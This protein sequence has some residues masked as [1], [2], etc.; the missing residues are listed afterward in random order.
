MYSGT[1]LTAM[2]GRILGAHQK[3]DRVA[4]RQLGVLLGDANNTFPGSREILRFE[5]R[6]GPDGIKRKSPAQNEPWHYVNP[7][8]DE[9][10]DLHTI[11]ADHYRQLAV[12]LKDEDST[13][14]AFEAAWLA[15]AIVDGLTPAHHYPYEQE[16]QKL[17]G[18][19]GLE[20]RN[21]IMRKIIMPGSKPSEQMKNNWKMW[22]PRGLMSTHGMFEFGIATII[23]PLKMK[24]ALPDEAS[25]QELQELGIVKVFQRKAKEIAAMDLYLTF[26]KTGWTPALAR[27]VR[28]ELAPVIVRAITLAW[29]GAALEAQKATKK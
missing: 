21:T 12:A 18:N 8:D 2:S 22:G 11:I 25:I 24:Q 16:L 29:Y 4:R 5:G 28:R 19:Q 17:R 9:D 23:A 1:T 26:Y 14:A 10:G 6:N 13:K 15:H 27:K 7:F 3:F 20:T